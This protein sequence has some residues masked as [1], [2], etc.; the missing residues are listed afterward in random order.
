MMHFNKFI[1]IGSIVK[2][3]QI[4]ESVNGKYAEFNIV[5][6]SV[7]KKGDNYQDWK[8]YIKAHVWDENKAKYVVEKF[9]VGDVVLIEGELRQIRWEDKKGNKKEMICIRCEKVKP[10]LLKDKKEKESKKNE[11]VISFDEI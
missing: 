10:I 5:F 3:P 4:K 1:G 7:Y 6:N 8:T 2:K 11:D 9:N